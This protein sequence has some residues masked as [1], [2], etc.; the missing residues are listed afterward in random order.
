MSGK[1]KLLK[2]LRSRI[3]FLTKLRV[4]IGGKRGHRGIVFNYR[5]KHG[6]CCALDA[7]AILRGI[8]PSSARRKFF[9]NLEPRQLFTM[10]HGEEGTGVGKRNGT[11]FRV[12]ARENDKRGK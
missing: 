11:C 8:D 5:L 3:N 10:K 12:C 2:L 1:A 7:S 4:S 9:G 6:L